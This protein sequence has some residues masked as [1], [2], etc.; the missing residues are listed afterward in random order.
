MFRDR[1]TDRSFFFQVEQGSKNH[2]IVPTPLIAQISGLRGGSGVNRSISTLAKTN[3]IAK[4]K[5]AKCMFIYGPWIVVALFLI[6]LLF[7]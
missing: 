2:E 6:I 4:V 3:L 5:N 7:C 1:K